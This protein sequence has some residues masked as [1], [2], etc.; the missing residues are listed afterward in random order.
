MSADLQEL[1]HVIVIIEGGLVAWVKSDTPLRVDVLDRDSEGELESRE[2]REE[3][4]ALGRK[5]EELE[6]SY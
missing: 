6:Y 5:A 4:D 3:Y 1:P 2:A